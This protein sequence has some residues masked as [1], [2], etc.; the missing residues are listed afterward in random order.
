LHYL[1]HRIT[2]VKIFIRPQV[3]IH[4]ASS[5]HESLSFHLLVR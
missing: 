3:A 4:I 2:F 5:Q 1:R